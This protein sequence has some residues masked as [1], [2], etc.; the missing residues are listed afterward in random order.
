MPLCKAHLS[1]V[2]RPTLPGPVTPPG[3]THIWANHASAEH[4]E[5]FRLEGDVRMGRDDQALSADAATYYKAQDRV[6]VK[7][8]VHVSQGGLA[9]QGTQGSFNLKED[10]GHLDDARYQYDPNRDHGRAKHIIVVNHDV[11]ELRDATLTT[12][13]P[14]DVV[15]YL[16]SSRVTL[17][18]EAGW[19]RAFSTVLHVKGVPVLYLPY[20]SFPISD[21]R[22]SGFLVPSFHST[23]RSGLIFS[24]PYYWDIAPNYDATLTPHY[25]TKR[26]MQY[27]TQFRYLTRAS[28][29][30]LNVQY[31]PNDR[32][33][34]GSRAF[35]SYDHRGLLAPHLSTD[36]GINYVTDKQYV[37]DFGVGLS[38]ISIPYLN[39]Y[40]DVAYRRRSG[41]I[42]GRLQAYQAVDPAIPPSSR[43]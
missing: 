9:L 10:S 8:N 41:Y 37:R 34:G 1:Y 19:G 12:C 31:L 7:G 28:R 26:G 13:D 30:E 33:Y 20:I 16:K 25:M 6:D 43:P 27:E 4:K 40:V 23:S 22:K 21:K 32:V 2:S 38:S 14:K 24:V 39:N 11:A 18:K 35:V 29:G 5:L 17:D 15:W 42:E 3:S 36:I